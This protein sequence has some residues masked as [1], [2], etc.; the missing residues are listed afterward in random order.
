[1][2]LAVAEMERLARRERVRAIVRSWEGPRTEI[3]WDRCRAAGSRRAMEWIFGQVLQ[4]RAARGG[5]SA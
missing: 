3:W 1:M 5:A 4:R 2:N